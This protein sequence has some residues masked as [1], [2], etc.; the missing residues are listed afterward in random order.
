VKKHTDFHV[1][2]KQLLVYGLRRVEVRL[3]RDPENF[4][5]QETHL[6]AMYI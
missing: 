2:A 3:L 5:L 6:E 4:S 1:L